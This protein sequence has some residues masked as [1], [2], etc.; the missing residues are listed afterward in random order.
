[1][2]MRVG[3]LLDLIAGRLR[4]E[5]ETALRGARLRRLLHL[6]RELGSEGS[7]LMVEVPIPKPAPRRRKPGKRIARSGSTV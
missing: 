7:D 3:A 2:Q 4:E 1:M 6:R 5:Q